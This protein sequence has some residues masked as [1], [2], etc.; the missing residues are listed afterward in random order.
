[1]KNNYFLFGMLTIIIFLFILLLMIK[2]PYSYNVQL[3]TKPYTTDEGA[4]EYFY[5]L[6]IPKDVD[7]N[8]I[9]DITY[10]A[11]FSTEHISLND[12]QKLEGNIFKLKIDFSNA[13]SKNIIIYTKNQTLANYLINSLFNWYN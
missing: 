12:I 3:I 9:S 10:K 2:I 7:Y 5:Y 4:I 8:K 13:I 1:M 6:Q 11:K